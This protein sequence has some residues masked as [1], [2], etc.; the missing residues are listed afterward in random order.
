MNP[1]FSKRI[2]CL[3]A[4]VVVV[5]FT[6]AF[7]VAAVARTWDPTAAGELAGRLAF[8]VGPLGFLASYLYQRG[9]KLLAGALVGALWA[10]LPIFLL[11]TTHHAVVSDAEREDLKVLPDRI[12]HP[13]FGFSLPNPGGTLR[14][15]PLPPAMSAEFAPLGRET[16]A[17][18]LRN[19]DSSQ[20]AVVLVFK[21]A[22]VIDEQ[23][24]RAFAEGMRRQIRSVKGGKLLEDTVQ[25]TPG[26]REYR[27][28]VRVAT[29]TY[30]KCTC[31]AAP[32]APAVVAC[33]QTWAREPQ[34]LDLVREGL[35]FERSP[36]R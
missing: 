15:V 27:L 8:V 6:I 32:Y 4:G 13:D 22:T 1:V 36:S 29:G 19:E 26:V 9:L 28:G 12:H 3:H 23:S 17:W 7:G 10:A 5:V 20:V 31:L 30:G 16:V 34:G 24:F 14:L 21:S 35:S 18:M 2:G 25:W 33:V 11:T